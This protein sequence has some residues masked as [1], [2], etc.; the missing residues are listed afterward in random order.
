MPR[1][2]RPREV[3]TVLEHLGWSEARQRGSH[4]ILTK[5]GQPGAPTVPVSHGELDPGTFSNI[6][7]QA[8]LNRQEFDAMAEEVL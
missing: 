8:G 7:R 3:I 2:Y 6:L 4:I 5:E 1:R